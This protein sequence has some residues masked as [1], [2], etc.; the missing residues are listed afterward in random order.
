MYIK[1]LPTGGKDVAPH[2]DLGEFVFVD[3]KKFCILPLLFMSLHLIN[4]FCNKL[5][6]T[7]GNCVTVVSVICILSCLVRL[8]VSFPTETFR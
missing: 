3:L 8:Y 5:P 1:L 4:Q 2:S 7:F 6:P